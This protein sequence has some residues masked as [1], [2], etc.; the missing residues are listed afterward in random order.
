MPELDEL[1]TILL[2]KVCRTLCPFYREGQEYR[3]LEYQC[4]AY[5]IIKEKLKNNEIKV[6]ELDKLSEKLKEKKLQ[7]EIA[8]AK[9]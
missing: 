3:E 6:D 9:Q 4:G 8:K 7:R 2:D 5:W 1:D